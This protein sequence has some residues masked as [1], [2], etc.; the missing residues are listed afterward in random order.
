MSRARKRSGRVRARGQ[1]LREPGLPLDTIG[2]EA[3]ER[4]ARVLARCGSS[5]PDIAAAF[6]AACDRL[7][8]EL[9]ARGT[10]AS[11][12]MSDVSHVLTVW[13]QDSLYLDR[14][15]VPIRLT[16]RGAAPSLEALVHRVDRGLDVDAVLRYLLRA[17][18]LRRFGTRYAPRSRALLLRGTGGPDSF[19]N[20]RGLV[21]MLRT[22]EHNGQP[23][24]SVRG[25]FEYF[26]ENPR[27]PARARAAF[28]T[29]LD[30]LG[31]KFLH[32]IDADMHRRE[33]ARKPSERTVRLGVGVY[34]F[35]DDAQADESG[36]GGAGSSATPRQR[37]LKTRRSA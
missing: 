24:R 21:A 12:E 7:P 14:E 20:L 16:V 8:K 4:F 32:A 31:M 15:G 28:D 35:E 34:R 13:F 30:E 29:R 6:A 36:S 25:W 10:R 18:A 27:F 19:R 17:Q 33:Q 3:I 11:R 2:L 23:K 37:K 22:V 1:A 26:A 5:P 9:L